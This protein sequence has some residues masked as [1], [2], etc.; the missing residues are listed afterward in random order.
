MDLPFLHGLWPML[1]VHAWSTN[2]CAFGFCI[3]QMNE[4]TVYA[5]ALRP[6]RTGCWAVGVTEW[7]QVNMFGVC[8]RNSLFAVSA[9]NLNMLGLWNTLIPIPYVHKWTSLPFLH[10]GP[11]ISIVVLWWRTD[12]VNCQVRFIY[13][14]TIYLRV[15][16]PCTLQSALQRIQAREKGPAR[17]ILR[18][19]TVHVLN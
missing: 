6:L 15:K 17:N 12:G 18:P 7:M 13:L 19:K 4:S 10:W 8:I 2:T 3:S 1:L 14:F 16:C 9:R 11:V 5:A